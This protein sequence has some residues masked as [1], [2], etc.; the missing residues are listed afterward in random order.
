MKG[1]VRQTAYKKAHNRRFLV[2][3][4]VNN[5]SDMAGVTKAFET[6]CSVIIFC[7]PDSKTKIVMW[8]RDYS[9]EDFSIAPVNNHRFKFQNVINS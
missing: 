4:E 3:F 1:S 2:S 6:K 5:R 8:L 7:C 9:K